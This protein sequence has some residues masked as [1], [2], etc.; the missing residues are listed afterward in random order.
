MTNFS[1]K[2]LK[3]SKMLQSIEALQATNPELA[4][5]LQQA[6]QAHQKGDSIAEAL[7][8]TSKQ[9]KLQRNEILKTAFGKCD[10]SFKQFTDE[11]IKFER[12]TVFRHEVKNADIPEIQRLIRQASLLDKLPNHRQL[13]DIVYS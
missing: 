6:M 5:F 13:H 9:R 3:N 11:I 7:E 12:V 8:L 10:K 1:L 2:D 4:L